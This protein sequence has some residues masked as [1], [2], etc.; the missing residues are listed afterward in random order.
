MKIL[1]SNPSFQYS[2]QTVKA[3]QSGGY[4]V[5]FATTYVYDETRFF[6]RIIKIILPS[7]SRKL[8]NKKIDFLN[9]EFIIQ[10]YAG[11]IFHFWYKVINDTLEERSFKEDVKHDLWVSGW[12]EQHKPDMVIGY[13]K[14]CLQTFQAVKRYNGKCYLDLAQV[15]PF[16]IKQLREKYEFFE[17][18]TGSNKLFKII[19]DK[20]ITEYKFAD[21]ILSLSQ[22]AKQTLIEQGILDSKIKVNQ[23]GYD[24]DIFFPKQKK[25]CSHPIK[26]IY[27][28]I[29]T[30]R[31]GIHL[32]LE[33]VSSFQSSDLELIVVGSRG[34]A[35]NILEKYL[36]YTQITY[37]EST[38]QNQLAN[39]FRNADVFV[40]P[41]FLDSWAAVVTEA[42]A[43][44]L[45]VITTK[46]VGASE[47]V[48]LDCGYV[49]EPG[50]SI[51]LKKAIQYFIDNPIRIQEMGTASA[52]AVENHHWKR[53]ENYLL[54][55]LCVE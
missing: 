54:E 29:I 21:Y 53:Y 40:F 11:L 33:A 13:E 36:S 38:S 20:K 50:D 9:R 17:A 26:L 28:G 37:Y 16:F 10:H 35:S 45:P 8:I 23:L 12:I 52:K 42:M 6:E 48:G 55:N 18:I 34:D 47:L 31:K 25:T 39:F 30:K 41:S 7:V 4:K 24:P 19:T 3:L 22:F 15:H 44:G 49:I 5:Y 14:S 46:N 32:L 51:A 2:L 43:C 1:V 27:A